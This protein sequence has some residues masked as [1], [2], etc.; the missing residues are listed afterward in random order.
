MRAN[1]LKLCGGLL[2]VALLL[3]TTPAAMAQEIAVSGPTGTDKSITFTIDGI[4]NKPQQNTT[5][6][7]G[8]YRE[9]GSGAP[10]DTFN[11]TQRPDQNCPDPQNI[12]AKFQPAYRP[13]TA[14][15]ILDKFWTVY[16]FEQEAKLAGDKE[17]ATC[18][19]HFTLTPP[20]S[21]NCNPGTTNTKCQA[22]LIQNNQVID[23]T[24]FGL[25]ENTPER[26][27][28]TIG[29]ISIG[30]VPDPP[31]RGQAARITAGDCP[32]DGG[33]NFTFW[34]NLTASEETL[35]FINTC[36]NT[37]PPSVSFQGTPNVVSYSFPGEKTTTSVLIRAVCRTP[38]ENGEYQQSFRAVR[39]LGGAEYIEVLN[40]L[41]TE[42]GAEQ[43]IDDE[44]GL[45]IPAVSNGKPIELKVGGLQDKC[46]YITI[47]KVGG[48]LLNPQSRFTGD[49]SWVVDYQKC[50]NRRYYL[51]Y[52]Y[53]HEYHQLI[54]KYPNVFAI[55]EGTVGS[56]NISLPTLPD[57]TYEI[58]LIEVGASGFGAD[59]RKSDDTLKASTK[60]LVGNGVLPPPPLPPCVEYRTRSGDTIA[61]PDLIKQDKSKQEQWMLDNEIDGCAK[62]ATAFFD[63]STDPKQFTSDL[64]R[65]ILGIS[66]AIALGVIIRAGYEVMMSKGDPEKLQQA[67]ERLTSAVVG[68]LFIIFSLVILEIIGVDILRIPGFS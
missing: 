28:D 31:T 18:T 54:D 6:Q 14:V 36:T 13:R 63:F 11:I 20:S 44:T 35:N 8:I 51:L 59:G 64:L 52:E 39:V 38:S 43:P 58:K 65:I 50:N 5:Y 29:P 42:T 57:G 26:T 60:I 16:A 15:P 2:A 1:L 19:Y 46:Y 34:Q 62:V 30:V 45:A 22:K 33:A 68:L 55:I 61:M 56:E 66:G 41:D 9:D 49:K 23:S 47:N 7:F 53:T 25:A 48:A 37:C 12:D 21:Y 17:Y 3:F 40:T 32:G 67:R 4:S 27:A 10:W 24:V